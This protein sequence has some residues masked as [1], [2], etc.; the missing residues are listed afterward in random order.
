MLT[1]AGEEAAREFPADM[2]QEVSDEDKRF[3]H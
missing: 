1:Q 2:T 3:T